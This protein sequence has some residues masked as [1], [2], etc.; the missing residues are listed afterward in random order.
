MHSNIVLTA[1]MGNTIRPLG[2]TG[3]VEDSRPPAAAPWIAEAFGPPAR[4]W[5][6]QAWIAARIRRIE[7]GPAALP[8]SGDAAGT[9]EPA[10][11][12]GGS[13][14]GRGGKDGGGGGVC[15][16][17][18]DAAFLLRALMALVDQR[19][20]LLSRVQVHRDAGVEQ[21]CMEKGA[22]WG[23][24]DVEGRGTDLLPSPTS[25]MYVQ[26]VCGVKALAWAMAAV[27][28][29]QIFLC[30]LVFSRALGL[31][32]RRTVSALLRQ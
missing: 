24:I 22:S 11:S 10:G 2:Q 1:T 30:F 32:S 3:P 15:S 21:V 25:F 9:D 17:P 6:Q 12:S 7:G 19:F 8:A 16:L 31:A 14:G 18:N 29:A 28:G 4:P 27:A 26:R 23:L 13:S 20:D 5:W